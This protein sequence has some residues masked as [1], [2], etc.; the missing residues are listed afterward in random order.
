MKMKVTCNT[1]TILNRINHV[2]KESRNWSGIGINTL[3]I[4]SP[5]GIETRD[6]LSEARCFNVSKT[7]FTT[8]HYIVLIENV[9]FV[10]PLD[11][12]HAETDPELS[13][14]RNCLWQLCVTW[15]SLA[16]LLIFLSDLSTMD[17]RHPFISHYSR[18]KRWPYFTSWRFKKTHHV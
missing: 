4:A 2:S 12:L 3:K 13:A 11:T 16:R 7:T 17:T 14:A 18:D 6:I 10:S 5:M 8:F 1:T 15:F 9:Y